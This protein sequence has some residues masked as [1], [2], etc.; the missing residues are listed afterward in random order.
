MKTAALLFSPGLDSFLA[1]WILSE[2]NTYGDLDIKRLYLDVGSRYSQYEI[3]FLNKWYPKDHF[4]YSKLFDMSVLEKDDA[5]IPNRNIILISFAQAMTSADIVFINST[6]DDRVNDG[7][8]QFREDLSK[9]L[10]E[11]AGKPILIDSV[12][13]EKEKSE[14][15]KQYIEENPSQ[16]NKLL[17]NTYSCYDADLFEEDDL[18]YYKL[19]NSKYVELGKTTIYGCLECLACYRRLCA[20]AAANIFLPFY[21]IGLVQKHMN[22]DINSNEF[23]NRYK[24]MNDYFKFMQWY[25]LGE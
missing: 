2:H 10:S 19:E 24:S 18:S 11:S 21:D 9:A 14:W 12:L 15:I 20:L 8:I 6:K 3:D 22:R 25:D 13:K 5:Y 23:P 16:M 1:D 7:S 17:N 4:K